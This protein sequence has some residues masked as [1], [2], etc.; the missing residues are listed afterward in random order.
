MSFAP[1]YPLLPALDTDIDRIPEREAANLRT[2][3]NK[4]DSAGERWT[5]P[6]FMTL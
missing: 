2:K 3:N 4:Q 6:A 5:G 1:N